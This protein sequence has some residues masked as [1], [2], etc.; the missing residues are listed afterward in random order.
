MSRLPS[1]KTA[2]IPFVPA[3]F[4]AL[5]FCT[6]FA[7]RPGVK[8]YWLTPMLYQ[9]LSLS[10]FG[11]PCSPNGITAGG[12]S[13]RTSCRQSQLPPLARRL[14]Q[15]RAYRPGWGTANDHR[16]RTRMGYVTARELGLFSSSLYYLSSQISSFYY[17]KLVFILFVLQAMLVI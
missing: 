15:G 4:S 3:I 17:L 7:P 6:D 12:H 1:S 11:C 14:Q 9:P 13:I 2:E 16:G 8:L 10:Y 5:R